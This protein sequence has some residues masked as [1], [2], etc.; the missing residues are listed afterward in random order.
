M[1]Y[2]LGGRMCPVRC[3]KGV[4]D[5]KIAQVPKRRREIGAI[6]LFA[7][8]KAQILHQGD[9]TLLKRVHRRLRLRSDAVLNKA[10]FGS[11]PALPAFRQRRSSGSYQDAAC[12]W[13]ARNEIAL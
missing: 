10:D 4:I 1:G 3:R 6:G 7:G 13:D 5:V 11:R 9:L 8:V 2:R 12:P